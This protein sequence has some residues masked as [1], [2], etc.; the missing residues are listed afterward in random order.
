M[1][2]TPATLESHGPTYIA[3]FTIVYAYCLHKKLCT[4]SHRLTYGTCMRTQGEACSISMRCARCQ[5][6]AY[7]SAMLVDSVF[8]HALGRPSSVYTL[9]R[10]AAAL[11]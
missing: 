10:A 3:Q 7:W 6:H 11:H 5:F 2:H 1:L 9:H 8:E 4:S